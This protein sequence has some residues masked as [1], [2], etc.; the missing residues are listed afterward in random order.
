MAA[1][2]PNGLCFSGRSPYL[3]LKINEFARLRI[4]GPDGV[5]GR[6]WS[7]RVI[8]GDVKPGK[9]LAFLCQFVPDRNLESTF[10][11]LGDFVP[12]HVTIPIFGNP[13]NNGDLLVSLR[14]ERQIN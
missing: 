10:D 8:F 9:I 7:R 14:D 6:G 4:R 3:L 12:I 11:I 2:W 5:H 1:T 13:N